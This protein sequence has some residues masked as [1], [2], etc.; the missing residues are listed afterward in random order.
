V[1]AGVD[2]LTGRE[3]RIKETAPTYADAKVALTRLQQ[4][5]DTNQHPKSAITIGEAIEQWLDVAELEETTRHA[6]A[7]SRPAASTPNSWSASTLGFTSAGTCASADRRGVT[8]AN[9]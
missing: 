6:S 2:P 4:Q 3:R 8:S 7:I 5:V 1:Y 9:P